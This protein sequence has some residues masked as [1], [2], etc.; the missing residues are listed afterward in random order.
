[1]FGFNMGQMS[2]PSCPLQA[3]YAEKVVDLWCVFVCVLQ[4]GATGDA[5]GY[6][7]M[8]KDAIEQ[9]KSLAV[10]LRQQG[11]PSDNLFRT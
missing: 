8:A 11:H 5:E 7:V 1:M 9:M 4:G 2:P 6:M 3:N 10:D